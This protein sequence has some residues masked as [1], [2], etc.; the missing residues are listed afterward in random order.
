MVYGSL[1]DLFAGGFGAGYIEGGNGNDTLM[2][3]GPCWTH[4]DNPAH[5]HW[6]RGYTA[7]DDGDTIYGGQNTGAWTLGKT[8]TGTTHLREGHDT[9]KGGAG[10]DWMNSDM[11]ADI[12]FGEPDNDWMYGGQEE[13]LLYGEESAGTLRGDL[14]G[15]TLDGGPGADHFILGNDTNTGDDRVDQARFTSGEAAG[16]VVYGLDIHDVPWIYGAIATPDQVA[17]PGATLVP[18]AQVQEPR[19]GPGMVPEIGSA[20]HGSIRT[21]RNAAPISLIHLSSVVM[22]V[23]SRLRSFPAATLLVTPARTV[24]VTASA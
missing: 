20:S 15:D 18:I 14:E 22:R 7:A 4:R 17:A 5:E 2:G 24:S 19:Y 16:N 6:S 21:A 12:L 8:R 11:E 3:N 23:P 1:D 10:D 13:N 9:L